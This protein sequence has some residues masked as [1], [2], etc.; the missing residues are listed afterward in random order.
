[1]DDYYYQNVFPGSENTC[2]EGAKTK[3]YVNKYERNSIAC[4][5]YIEFYG[6]KCSICNLDFEERYG[7]IGNDFIH[8]HH[9]VTLNEIGEEYC[10]DHIK[11]LIPVCPNCHAMLH[12]EL[13]G[14]FCP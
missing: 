9:L 2:I 1:M 4:K 10:V 13:N 7:E 8:V 14:E 3:I 11:N 6:C 12:R 5:K